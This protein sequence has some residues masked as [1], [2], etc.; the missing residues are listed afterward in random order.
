MYYS[1]QHS[2]SI[3]IQLVPIKAQGQENRCQS[4]PKARMTDALSTPL[5]PSQRRSPELVPFPNHDELCQPWQVTPPLC[6]QCPSR[7]QTTSVLWALQ[8]DR[9]RNQSLRQPSNKVEHWIYS[10]LFIL[11]RKK[12]QGGRFFPSAELDQLGRR[13]DADKMANL[14]QCHGSWL[15]IHLGC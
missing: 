6:S 8:V 3:Q 15:C 7:I 14:F 10:T 4:L 13:A 11:L 1:C 9:N 2:Q 5:L 12:F